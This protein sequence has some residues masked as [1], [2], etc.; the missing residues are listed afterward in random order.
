MPSSICCTQA[1]EYRDWKVN[2]LFSTL[3]EFSYIGIGISSRRLR[4]LIAI[5]KIREHR[6][7]TP[8]SS[9]TVDKKFINMA[10]RDNCILCPIFICE[11]PYTL[12]RFTPIG[13]SFLLFVLADYLRL[14][15]IWV[16]HAR[17]RSR[18][19][20]HWKD[21]EN[22]WDPYARKGYNNFLV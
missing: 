11:P 6:L 15:H 12:I 20:T 16:V 18:M 14:L 4:S 13:C 2:L 5:F 9:P 21:P 3:C 19:K 22:S 17:R 1:S 8:C 10:N 7:S